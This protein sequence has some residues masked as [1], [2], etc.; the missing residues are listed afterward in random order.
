M[1]NDCSW[2]W[3]QPIA[4]GWG[5]SQVT[6]YRPG[7]MGADVYQK[8]APQYPSAR[9]PSVGIRCHR[10]SAEHSR[11]QLTD[12]EAGN[13]ASQAGPSRSLNIYLLPLQ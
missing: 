13:S 10:R 7:A 9:D 11:M 6:V 12:N 8:Q 4:G 2:L 3:I 1:S 5:G